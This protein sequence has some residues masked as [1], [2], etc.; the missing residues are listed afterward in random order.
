LGAVV[1]L[2]TPLQ[3]LCNTCGVAEQ[4]IILEHNS[5][6]TKALGSNPKFGSGG[7]R[8]MHT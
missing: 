4:T 2:A 8:E 6:Q 1:S 3:I 5:V 7:A